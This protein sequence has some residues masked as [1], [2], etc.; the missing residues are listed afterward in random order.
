MTSQSYP[1]I[2]TPHVSTVNDNDSS[3]QLQCFQL[4][5]SVG[6]TF[7]LLT[8]FSGTLSTTWRA[9]YQQR[10]YCGVK[11]IQNRG[12]DSHGYNLLVI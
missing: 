2:N 3:L 5:Y 10:F 12:S 4:E 9:V 11:N 1:H 6:S 8:A 7:K